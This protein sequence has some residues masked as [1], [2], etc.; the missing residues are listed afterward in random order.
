MLDWRDA[1]PGGSGVAFQ[2]VDSFK[3]FGAGGFIVYAA[4]FRYEAYA[5]VNQLDRKSTR[6]NSSH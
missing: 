3:D 2:I 5:A 1:F 6:L 4:E